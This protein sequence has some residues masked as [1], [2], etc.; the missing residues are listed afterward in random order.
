M[1][2]G[3]LEKKLDAWVKVNQ[4]YASAFSAQRMVPD[5]VMGGSSGSSS[6]ASQLVDL[7][8][9]TTARQIGLS[10]QVPGSSSRL[11]PT[12]AKK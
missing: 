11:A 7:L 1:A 3:A 12:P 9:A 6:N 4:A 5:V 2:D 10:M 8:T